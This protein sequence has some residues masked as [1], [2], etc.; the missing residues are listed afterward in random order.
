LNYQ[1]G[2]DLAKSDVFT[3]GPSALDLDNFSVH[4][5]TTFLSQYALPFHSPY[6]G[7]NS[8]LPNEGRETWDVDFFVGVRPWQG[9]EVWISPEIDQGFGL[10]G[11]FG[12]AGFPSAEAYKV[13][14][15]LPYA[16][17]PRM[18]LR[19]T[20][21]LGGD[22]QKVESAANQFAGSQ[23][24]DRLVITV[25]KF[26]VVDIFDTNKYAH[27][28]RADFLNWTLVDTGA[29]D[30]AADAWA[31]TYGS[32]IEWFK[33]QWTFRAGVFDAPVIPNNTDLDPTFRQFQIVSE[34]ERR[35]E[36]WSQP[37]KIA[38]TGFLTRARMGSFDAAIQ[39]AEE[40]GQP[41]NVALVRTYT[42]KALGPA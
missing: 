7:Q 5:Q 13:G 37:G 41:A 15:S 31:F 28:P 20:I 12:V 38:V 34:I 27:D 29:F 14:E 39:L 30:Y 35:Y 18:F 8:L 2:G 23:T 17:I 19:Q 11:T 36:L 32:A 22:T 16:R 25:G 1:L 42:R 21:D 40:T 10:S 24:A 26:S 33:D 3:K 6:Q 4:G 9:A